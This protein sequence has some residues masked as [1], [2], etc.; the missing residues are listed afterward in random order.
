MK[1][2]PVNVKGFDSLEE[3]A[4]Q[5]GSM[6]YDKLAEFLQY[7]SEEIARQQE[8]DRQ[9]GKTKLAADSEKLI[10]SLGDASADAQ[11]LFDTYK[12][13]MEHEL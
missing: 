11:F 8:K 4:I 1:K 10:S 2:H 9:V 7:L 13:F 12:K 5:V 6:R 3:L